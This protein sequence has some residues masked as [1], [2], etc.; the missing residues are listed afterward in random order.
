MARRKKDDSS[1][2]GS[3]IDTYADMVTLLLT[4]FIMLF[5][6]SNVRESEWKKLV[7]S[8]RVPGTEKN[9][10]V[11]SGG[12]NP[13]ADIQKDNDGNGSGTSST[14]SNPK[15]DGEMDFD[16]LFEYLQQYVTDNGLES[17]IEVNEGE[18]CVYI[19]FSDVVIFDA[20]SHFIKKDS[21]E[22]LNFLGDALKKVEKKLMSVVIAGHTAYVD[23]PYAVSD[24]RLSGERAASVAIYLQDD[25]GID[26][27][28]IQ[29][30]GHGANYPIAS[31]KTD[32]GRKK[33]RR[34]E[35]MILSKDADLSN[36]E[37][38]NY[39][40][41]GTFDNKEYPALGGLEDVI[42]PPVPKKDNTSDTS[43]K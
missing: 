8:F 39:L 37:I 27:K 42:I 11:L 31:N 12:T 9:E 32:A 7:K 34:V 38:I 15:G 10:I 13:V 18:S 24:R 19:R 22:L 2:G 14:S 3:W 21:R 30:I 4:F 23:G 25:K 29:S 16:T 5:S 43:S 1:V 26:P 35:L 17:T 41:K 28:K 40:L 20:D 33:N 6:I 36:E